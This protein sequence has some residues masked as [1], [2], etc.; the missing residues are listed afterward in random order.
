MPLHPYASSIQCES[1][2]TLA[3]Q[4]DIRF[5]VASLGDIFLFSQPPPPTTSSKMG[6]ESSKLRHPRQAL[7]A[8]LDRKSKSRSPNADRKRQAEANTSDPLKAQ[9]PK[10]NSAAVGE[11]ELQKAS[12]SKS[13]ARDGAGKSVSQNVSAFFASGTAPPVVIAVDTIH[14]WAHTPEPTSHFLSS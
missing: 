12:S 13:K 2:A 8:G 7:R 1:H 3:K 10:E 6:A 4:V 14:L 9:G 5:A 11:G